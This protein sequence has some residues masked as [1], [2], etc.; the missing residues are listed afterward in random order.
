MNSQH[1]SPTGSSRFLT[2]RPQREDAKTAKK[3]FPLPLFPGR[4]FLKH[5]FSLAFS[6][7]PLRLCESYFFSS[8][9]DA[10]CFERFLSR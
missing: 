2:Q 5:P 4:D 9:E 10:P 6:L 8:S 3:K 7:R 1:F